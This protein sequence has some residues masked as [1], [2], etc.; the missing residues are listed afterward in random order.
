V[1]HGLIADPGRWTGTVAT[2]A[3]RWLRCDGAGNAC[4]EVP[5]D[6]R[7]EYPLHDAD[8]GHAIRVVVTAANLGGAASATS[9]PSAAVAA[10]PASAADPVI[11]AAGD[12]ACSPDDGSFNSGAGTATACRQMATSDLLTGGGLT[13]VLPLGDM[14]YECPTASSLALSYDPSWGRVKAI[15]HPVPGNHEYIGAS[16]PGC[17]NAV[18]AYYSYFGAAA[19]NPATGYYS[20]DLGDWHVIALNTNTSC[21]VIAC[22]AGSAQEQWLQA[23]LAA[24]PAA[25]TLAYFHEPLFTSGSGEDGGTNAVRPFWDALQAAGAEVILNGHVHNY[26]RFAPQSPAGAPDPAGIREIVVGTGGKSHYAIGAIAANSE[27]R[28]ANAFGVLRMTLHPDGYDWQFVPAAGST[29]ADS[30]SSP[31]H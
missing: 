10:S 17:T 14:Q 29:F 13:A 2:F 18:D 24:H 6:T 1:G 23:D 27:V 9:A 7:A 8:A 20:Y 28:S 21:S 26:E 16:R 30:G 12:I 4:A 15:S 19:G 22:S 11:A 31:C 3:Y 5:G 25:C